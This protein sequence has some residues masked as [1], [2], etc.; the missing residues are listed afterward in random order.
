[1]NKYP[2]LK[3]VED[4]LKQIESMMAVTTGTIGLERLSAAYAAAY[5]I[6]LRVLAK[7]NP[8]VGR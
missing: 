4:V 8:H 3:D 6:K 1:M 5:T 2:P 7:E